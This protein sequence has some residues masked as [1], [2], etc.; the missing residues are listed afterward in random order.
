M[1]AAFGRH[2]RYAG[3]GPALAALADSEPGEAN[4]MAEC[5]ERT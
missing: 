1:S 5:G 3:V 2:L 4:N